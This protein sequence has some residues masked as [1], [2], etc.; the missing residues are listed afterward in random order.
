MLMKEFG[1]GMNR[2]KD[3]LCSQ[4]GRS[5]IV[6]M[7]KIRKAVYIFNA[8]SIKLTMTFS[9]EQEQKK[10]KFVWKHKDFKQPN[11]F[12][13]EEWNQRNHAP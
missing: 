1:D 8:I 10:F 4:I 5:N 3:I 12:K 9:P 7:I 11:N 13:K 2:R 6:K